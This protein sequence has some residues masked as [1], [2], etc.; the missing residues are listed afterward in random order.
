[1]GRRVGGG[2]RHAERDHVPSTVS[3]GLLV[4]LALGAGTGHRRDGETMER[5]TPNRLFQQS[6]S[7]VQGG[8]QFVK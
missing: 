3:R 1:M 5:V 8:S 7:T 4:V 2:G 6:C